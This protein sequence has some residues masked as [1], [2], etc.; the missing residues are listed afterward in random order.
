MSYVTKKLTHLI[1]KKNEIWSMASGH[2]NNAWTCVRRNARCLEQINAFTRFRYLDTFLQ[3]PVRYVLCNG[4]SLTKILFKVE[5]QTIH[6]SS[7]WGHKRIN[8]L[9]LYLKK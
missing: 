4:K 8:G 5:I 6:R 3:R 1:N 2:G 7:T 9:L